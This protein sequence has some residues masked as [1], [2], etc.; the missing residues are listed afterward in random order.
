MTRSR[1]FNLL[2]NHRTITLWWDTDYISHIGSYISTSAPFV[3]AG[4]IYNHRMNTFPSRND[5]HLPAHA[6]MYYRAVSNSHDCKRFHHNSYV[7]FTTKCSSCT[8]LVASKWIFLYDHKLT[9]PGPCLCR[10]GWLGTSEPH[11]CQDCKS[12]SCSHLNY[13]REQAVMQTPISEDHTRILMTKWA[14]LHSL[15][16][17]PYFYHNQTVRVMRLYYFH[18]YSRFGV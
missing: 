12:M 10:N 13:R 3:N 2:M 16:T 18:D 1:W 15:S 6:V 9:A 5:T 17:T 8:L 4:V 14:T 11:H 7:L